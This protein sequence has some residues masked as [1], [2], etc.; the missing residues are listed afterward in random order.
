M[1]S[2]VVVAN[3][4]PTAAEGKLQFFAVAVWKLAILSFCSGGLYNFYWF[5]RHWR[6]QHEYDGREISPVW[7]SVFQIFFCYRLF[8]DVRDAE[9][10]TNGARGLAT[11]WLAAGFI[12]VSLLW[13]AP[14]P[15]WLIS[16]LAFVFL[17]PVQA[18]A[19]RVNA[20]AAPSHDP[21]ARLTRWNWVLIMIGGLVVV[22]AIVG[23]FLPDE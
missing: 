3:E 1:A 8:E 18:A 6:A 15:Y 7:R 22:L 5:Y 23:T 17:L 13:R 20:A 2:S 14:D 10:E 11:G 16:L 21:N 12:I 19:N 9:S 4:S